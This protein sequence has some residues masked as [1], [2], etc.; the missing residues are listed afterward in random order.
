MRH[1][2]QAYWQTALQKALALSTLVK[3]QILDHFLTQVKVYLSK[4]KKSK[5]TQCCNY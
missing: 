2:E 3:V 5:S 1:L 4:S